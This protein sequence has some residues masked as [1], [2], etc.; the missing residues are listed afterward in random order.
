M[1]QVSL[2]E[3]MNA[4]QKAKVQANFQWYWH[5]T[6]RQQRIPMVIANRLPRR[7]VYWAVIRAACLAEPQE[8]PGE[9]TAL[10]M[11]K[12]LEPDE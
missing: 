7:V 10:E 4:W 2:Y 9:K 8:Y 1:Q 5:V 11:L 6:R 12:A 3:G